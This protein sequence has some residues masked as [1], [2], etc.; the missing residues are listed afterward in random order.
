MAYQTIKMKETNVAGKVPTIAQM[1][2][3]ELCLNLKDKK[4][5]T[6]DKDG[7][8]ITVGT[9]VGAG[10]GAPAGD[11]ESAGDLYWDGTNL[12]VWNLSLIHI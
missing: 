4:L 12:L 8:I 2:V 6:R 9:K 7:N 10:T 1:A 3:A 11:G 5:Y